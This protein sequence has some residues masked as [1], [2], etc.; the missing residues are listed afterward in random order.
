[1]ASKRRK[2]RDVTSDFIKSN[3]F[4]IKEFKFTEKQKQLIKIIRD[5]NAKVIFLSGP[6]G[7][8]K[9][10]I[11]T[12]GGLRALSEGSK[13]KMIYVRGLV[14]NSKTCGFLPGT[15]SEKI[16]QYT[17]PLLDKLD[18]LLS[19]YDSEKLIKEGKI[20]CICP[21][22]LRGMSLRSSYCII[23]ESQNLTKKELVTILSRIGEN[24]TFVFCGDN[25]QSDIKN[26][27]FPE[28]ASLFEDEEAEEN[29]IYNFQ[30]T[31]EDIMRS[32]VLRFIMS[33]LEY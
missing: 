14:E 6:A 28:V 3:Q 27:A 30:F 22:F 20:E 33:R 8:S 2:E 24:S 1:M 7:S 13:E 12:Y 32:Q 29:G 19:K 17:L 21:N 9:T 11:A 4:T 25:F 16:H 18:E 10:L 15:I 5:K 26:G 23:D 31:A